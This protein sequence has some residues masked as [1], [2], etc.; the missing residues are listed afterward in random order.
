M[1]RA[2]ENTPFL[3]ELYFPFHNPKE[4]RLGDNSVLRELVQLQRA[5]GRV[6][7]GGSA[8]AHVCAPARSIFEGLSIPEGRGSGQ[9]QLC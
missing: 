7:A 9:E 5:E 1:A 4:G 6:C 3:R 2:T 8:S